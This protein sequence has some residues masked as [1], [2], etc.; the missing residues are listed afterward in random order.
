MLRSLALVALTF[1]PAALAVPQTY[2]LPS[3]PPGDDCNQ[4]ALVL[5]TRFSQST[6]VDAIGRCERLTSHGGDLSF[7]YDRDEPLRPVTTVGSD[8]GAEYGMGAYATREACLAD[9]GVAKVQFQ[10]ET[11]LAPHIAYCQ[12]ASFLDSY[13][14]ALR[15]D[16]FG[17]AAKRPWDV[18]LSFWGKVADGSRDT[19]VASVAQTLEERGYPTLYTRV[20]DETGL[21]LFGIAYYSA[22]PVRIE[23]TEW[24]KLADEASCQ[25]AATTIRDAFNGFSEPPLATFCTRHALFPGF[26]VVNLSFGVSAVHANRAVETYPSYAAC[27]ADRARLVNYYSTTLRRPVFGGVC[28]AADEDLLTF[29]TWQVVLIEAL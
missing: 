28:S 4:T 20:A 13:P 22:E 21:G 3:Y 2:R 17:E 26:K 9:L 12:F 16:A 10:A 14:Y 8:V 1:A 7:T 11:G 5:A 25:A 24:A 6:G 23:S 15:I 18:W 27:E 29:R 19:L